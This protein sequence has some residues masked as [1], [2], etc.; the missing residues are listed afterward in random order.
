MGNRDSYGTSLNR[1]SNKGYKNPN[2]KWWNLF[3]KKSRYGKKYKS[4]KTYGG[5]RKRKKIKK[6]KV[7][8]RTGFEGL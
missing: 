2:K 8:L 7:K 6:K 4:R 3:G 5:S 1:K